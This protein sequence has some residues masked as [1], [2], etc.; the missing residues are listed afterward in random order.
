[1]PGVEDSPFMTWGQLEATPQRA[2]TPGGASTSDKKVPGVSTIA[3][4]APAFR[5]D[6]SK[7][8]KFNLFSKFYIL[9]NDREELAHRLTDSAFSAK[10][11]AKE[12]TLS[13]AKKSAF[14]TTP[15]RLGKSMGKT[16]EMRS[17]AL[18]VFENLRK[19]IFTTNLAFAEQAFKQARN[20]QF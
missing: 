3:A 11:N 10:R 17:P 4:N 1:M 7:S 12:R 8:L 15:H 14:G 13:G 2:M 18:N 5:M 16:P 6:S 9:V 19:R 20:R